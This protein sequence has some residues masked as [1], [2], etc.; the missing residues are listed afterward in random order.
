[1]SGSLL[2]LLCRLSVQNAKRANTCFLLSD[3]FGFPDI[4]NKLIFKFIFVSN[5]R[6]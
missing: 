3:P 1:M 2:S 4:N 6:S 5:A